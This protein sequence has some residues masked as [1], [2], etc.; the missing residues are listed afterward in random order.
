MFS[1][2]NV[3][4]SNL[5][6]V[7]ANQNKQLLVISRELS[8][9]KQRNKSLTYQVDS[10]DRIQRLCNLIISGIQDE[11][12]AIKLSFIQVAVEKMHVSVKP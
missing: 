8:L 10:H 4:I 2:Y 1:V 5:E 12:D 9:L 6:M 11:S 3:R 7:V